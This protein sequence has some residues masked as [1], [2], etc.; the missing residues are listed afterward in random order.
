MK[1]NRFYG[2]FYAKDDTKKLERCDNA[3]DKSRKYNNCLR[4]FQGCCDKTQ[5]GLKKNKNNLTG[6][7]KRLKI[8]IIMLR[9]LT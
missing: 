5:A 8:H 7:L 2:T 1:E 4:S 9:S 6:M 3:N